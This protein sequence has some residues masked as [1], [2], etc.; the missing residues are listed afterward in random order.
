MP[1]F[2]YTDAPPKSFEPL[3]PGDYLA[4][5]T[6]CEFLIQQG[7]KTSGSDVMELTFETL[8][9][10]GVAHKFFERLIFHE[11]TGWKIDTFVKSFNLLIDAKPP[12]KGQAIEWSERMVVGLQGWVTLKVE[13]YKCRDDTMKKTN[14]VAVFITNKEKLPKLVEIPADAAGEAEDDVA[15]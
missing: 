6:E 2:V 1:S 8:D 9:K 13:E 7:G 15:F 14:R 12:A 11:S 5:V 4:Q 3:P 10:D